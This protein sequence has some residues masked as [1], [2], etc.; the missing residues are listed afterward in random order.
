MSN[1][2]FIT[3]GKNAVFKLSKCHS[4]LDCHLCIVICS[5]DASHSEGMGRLVNDSVTQRK[6]NVVLRPICYNNRDHLCLFVAGGDIEP[7]TE[8]CYYY[9][10]SDKYMY[11]RKVCKCSCCKRFCLVILM[12][13]VCT[14]VSCKLKNSSVVLSELFKV[15]QYVV[16]LCSFY[17]VMLLLY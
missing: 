15:A 6:A 9:G 12:K 5:V 1:V 10:P 11:W 7:G 3:T 16:K 2:N 14:I 4:W 13:F 17:F 8:L